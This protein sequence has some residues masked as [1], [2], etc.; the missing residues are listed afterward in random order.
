MTLDRNKP[1]LHIKSQMHGEIYM[2]HYE[3]DPRLS[4]AGPAHLEGGPNWRGD[5]RRLAGAT[6]PQDRRLSLAA[7][8]ETETMLERG[9]ALCFGMGRHLPDTWRIL[10][11]LSEAAT[12]QYTTS[13]RV[14]MLGK[15]Y[16]RRK[17]RSVGDNVL[18][19]KKV[20]WRRTASATS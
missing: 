17:L 13:V 9:R 14:L 11:A 12:R 1:P 6:H 18:C 3:S 4:T 5:P 15:T 7:A 8:A 19:H 16:I 2:F 10:W 20:A